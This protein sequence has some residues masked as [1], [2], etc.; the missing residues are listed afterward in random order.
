MKFV[1]I[2]ASLFIVLAMCTASTLE[3]KKN[4]MY[5][6]GV[7]ASFTDS[8][9]YFT[10]I[11]FVDSVNVDKN[12]LLPMRSQYSDQLENYLEQ[13]KGMKNR[14]CFI[15]FNEKKS[16]LEKNINK[17]KE[18]YQK[19]GKSILRELGDEFKFTKAVAEY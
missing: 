5:I 10:D 18:N 9:I 19:E 6:V 12:K 14:T 3:N 4:G 8:L 1:K 2:V 13:V 16:K 17:M 15:Y 11:Q 7:S